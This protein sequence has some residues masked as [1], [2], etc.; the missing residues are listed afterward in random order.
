MRFRILGPLEIWTGQDWSGIGAPKWRAVLAALLLNPG[1]VVSTERLITELWDTEPP[2]GAA[3]LVSVYVLR[4]RR[5]IGDRKGDILATRAP[6][7]QLRL[8][9]GDLDATAFEALTRQG[10][11]ALAAGN[12]QSAATLLTEAL[13]LWRGDALSDIPPSGLV[14][15]EADRLGESRLTALELRITADLH[16]GLAAQLVPELRRL[17]SDS[18][19]REGLWLLL[20][21]ALDSAGRRAEAVAA[22][23]EARQVLADELGVDP[24]PDLRRL[25]Q[26]LLSAEAD[27]RPPG[28]ALGPDAAAAGAGATLAAGAPAAAPAGPAG[29]RAVPAGPRDAEPAGPPEPAGQPVTVA[30]AARSAGL[31]GDQDTAGEPRGV[32]GAGGADGTP[33][34]AQ[35]P[36]DLAD[37]TGRGAHL[38]RLRGLLSGASGTTRQ[39]VAVAVV[40]GTPGLGKTALAVHAAHELRQE[41]G[42]GQL[43]V[44]LLGA[45]EQP[46]VPGEI[47]A[48]LLRDLGVNA[49]QI[50]AGQEERAALYRTRLADRRVLIV[51]D[52]ARDAAQVRPLLPGSASCAVI[53]TSRHRLADLAGS[54]LVDL[55]VLDDAEARGLLTAI[56][57]EERAAAEPG[58]VREVLDA[59]AG[60]P[61]AI[62]IAGARLTA[63]RG[64]AVKTLARRLADQHRRVAELT[65]G[66]LAVRACFDV[67]F[68]SLRHLATGQGVDPA[69]AFRLL[70]LWQGPHI[71]LPAAAALLGQSEDEVADA[72]EVLVDANLLESPAPDIYRFHD[73]LRAYAAE[74]ALAQEPAEAVTEAVSRVL[75]WYLRTADAAAGVV[76]RSR[77]RVPLGAGG[78]PGGALAFA[79][80]EEALEWSAGERANL[81]AATRQAAAYDLHDIAWKL[82]VAVLV[83]FDRHGYRAEWVA[84][85]QVALDSARRSGDRHGEAWVLNNLGMVHSQLR[86]PDATSYL[87]QALAIHR[88]RGD[89]HGQAQ[90]T[91]NIAFDFQIR[92]M[93]SE[94][95]PAL[96]QALELQRQVGHRYGEGVALSNFGEA[97]LELG[98]YEEAIASLQEALPIVRETGA[99]RVEANILCNLGRAHMDLGQ[100][101]DGATL[102]EQALSVQ[103]AERDKYGQA[104]SLKY[105]GQAR[106]QAGQASAARAA[107]EE[108]V[109]LLESLADDKQAAGLR[110][111]LEELGTETGES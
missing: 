2:A 86:S 9:P 43:Y 94:A 5:L 22:F 46:V 21:R 56:I 59:C 70:G 87:E 90:V 89:R 62:R 72:L 64:W 99:R 26:R 1:Q 66:D 101:G 83:C 15:A 103:R 49:H 98:R 67:S 8:E 4:V 3:N 28:P 32:S 14:T 110:S 91:N 106:S 96:A 77:E 38:A 71:S 17:I 95:L 33:T 41:F 51:L 58:P 36:A 55:D 37:F 29:E 27:A 13:A 20:M 30:R 69:H 97:F 80:G 102:L 100:A 45:S 44:S 74:R 82:P 34:P 104:G 92:G 19:L 65:A 60:L 85:H 52:D 75:W 11:A 12:A 7:Y 10:R 47:L 105:L 63:R 108:A 24:G 16:C 50:P 93:H 84:T 35:L 18:P 76:T 57:G 6:G 73:L 23:G 48:R 111:R 31:T 88:E 109:Q 81:V 61:L 68:E 79:T 107:W 39:A 42:D 54:R 53:V 78:P 40:A 25:Y